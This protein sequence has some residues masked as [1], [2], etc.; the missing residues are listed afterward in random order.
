MVGMQ[1]GTANLENSMAVPQKVKNRTTLQCSNCIMGYL[2]QKYKTLIQTDTRTPMFI[3]ALLTIAKLWKQ[4]KCPSTDEGIKKMWH[5][6]TI[7]YY[8]AI[9]KNEISPIS[10]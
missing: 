9:K 3:A 7:E 4:H 10:T 6:Y 2:L 8:S 1:T 5:I